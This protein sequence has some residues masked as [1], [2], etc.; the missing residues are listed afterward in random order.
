VM[1]LVQAIVEAWRSAM[2]KG[3]D[4]AVLLCDAQLRGHLAE[5]LR[6]QLPQLS[7]VAYEEIDIGTSV[8]GIETV[9]IAA[10]TNETPAVSASAP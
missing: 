1:Q 3:A 4:K 6:R 10:D 8:E 5:M 7:V 9:S 2:D